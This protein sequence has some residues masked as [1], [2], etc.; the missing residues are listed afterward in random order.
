MKI[1]V[2]SGPNNE[3][4][5]DLRGTIE[6]VDGVLAF[7][8]DEPQLKWYARTWYANYMGANKGKEPTA[9]ELLA[10]ILANETPGRVKKL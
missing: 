1:G 10:F 5:R 2:Y 7:T 3:G 4:L 8:I 6:D 9:D